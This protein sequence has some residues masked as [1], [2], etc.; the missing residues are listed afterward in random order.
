MVYKVNFIVSAT[1]DIGLTKSTNQ[2]S[3]SVRVFSTSLG[4]VVFAILCDGM[5]GLSKGEVASGSLVNAFCKWADN[6]LPILCREDITESAIRADWIG[7]A[8]EYNEKIKFY[9]RSCGTSMGTTVTAILLTPKRYYIINVGD[10]RAYEITDAVTVLTKDQTVVAREVELGHL[11][12]EEAKRDSRRSVLLQCVGASE[13]V[14]P[15][16]FFGDTKL[17]AVYMLCSDG[18]RHEITKDEIYQYLGPN[19]MVDAE[20]MKQNMEALI[21]LNK[22]RQERDNISVISI[23]TF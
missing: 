17:N 3:Y 20:G 8:T 1:T 10:T 16:M 13:E 5:G 18:F 15:D 2:D 7:I 19:V 22:Q 9:G 12:P 23:R 6:R 11:T 14:Y 21:E 4:K